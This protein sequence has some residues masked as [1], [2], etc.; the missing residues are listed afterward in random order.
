MKVSYFTRK[1]FYRF[2]LPTIISSVCLG[3]ANLADALC[4]GLLLGDPALAAISLISP[5]FMVFNVLDV[6]IAVGAAVGFTRLMASGHAKQARELFQQMFLVSTVISVILAVVGIIFIN[7]ILVALGTSP[8]Q[9]EV[10]T[11]TK[12]YAVRLILSAPV[13]FIN[14]L[15]YH[16]IRCDDGEKRAGIAMTVQTILDV[17]LSFVLV[18]GFGMGVKGAIWATTIGITVGIAIYIP[19]FLHKFTVLSLKFSKPDF[20]NFIRYFKIGFASSNQYLAQFFLLLI[21]NNLL[22]RIH[23]QGAV[24]ILNV[25]LNVSYVLLG[26]FEGIGATIVP[27]AGTFMSERNKIAQRDT[28][29]LSFRWAAGLG[30]VSIGLCAIFAPQIA[31]VF[32][33][34]AGSISIGASALRH[35]FVS[36]VFAAVSI[37]LCSYWQAINRENETLLLT[38]LRSFMV[39]ITIAIPL[40]FGTLERY[41]LVFPA[42][43]IVSLLIF[44]LVRLHRRKHA[45]STLSFE[46]LDTVQVIQPKKH[47]NKRFDISFENLDAEQSEVDTGRKKFELTFKNLDSIP[48]LEHMIEQNLT[49]F[50]ELLGR[51]EEYCEKLNATPMQLNLANMAVE[52]TCGVIFANALSKKQKNTYIQITLFPIANGLFEL[53]IRDD[54]PN[55]N[56]FSIKT[57]KIEDTQDDTDIDFDM[58][59]MGILMVKSKAKEFFYR[60]YQG[61]N[62]LTI[63][64]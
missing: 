33:L 4:V 43:E 17:A 48:P 40:S 49:D 59:N 16:S 61:F 10:Y 6:G 5:I 36:A 64:I 19:H 32:G 52:E 62:T 8:A 42:T 13:F 26:I 35:Y 47:K 11:Y 24:A 22:M 29:V 57:K 50:G 7:P 56:P 30:I 28:M 58:S 54:G 18:L 44:V 34:S 60:H 37:L 3:I 39:Y 15:F 51:V 41:W 23:G 21:T 63:R 27:L 9:G 38:T 55:F 20:T 12:D 25:V 46:N 2:F 45:T 1:I 31:T 14:Q 53:H